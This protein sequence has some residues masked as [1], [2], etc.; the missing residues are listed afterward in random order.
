MA[1]GMR[2]FFLQPK[3]SKKYIARG[4]TT[5]IIRDPLS[6]GGGWDVR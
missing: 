6:I 4:G 2:E 3:I 1:T 5:V